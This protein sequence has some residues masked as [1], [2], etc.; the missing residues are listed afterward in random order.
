MVRRSDSR[1]P[2]APAAGPDFSREARLIA[3]GA[4]VVAGV[5]EAGR[6]P[7]AGPVAVAAVVLDPARIPAGLDD[8]KALAPAVRDRLA[9]AILAEHHVAVVLATAARIDRMNIRAATLWAMARAVAA[10][11]VTVDHVLVDGRDVPPGLACPG[12]AVV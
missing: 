1:R 5:D 10:L 8:S 9:A 6:G 7:L 11:P 2:G 3:A 4:H 12:D